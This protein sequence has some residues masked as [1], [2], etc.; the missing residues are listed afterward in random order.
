M[1]GVAV[2]LVVGRAEVGLAARSEGVGTSDVTGG[3]V[4]VVAG[5]ATSVGPGSTAAGV[6]KL[7]AEIKRLRI[8]KR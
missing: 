4:F 5:K 7:Q 2:R 3:G 6:G 1:A 8:S